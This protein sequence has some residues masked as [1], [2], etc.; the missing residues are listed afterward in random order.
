MNQPTPAALMSSTIACGRA[1]ASRSPSKSA[2]WSES[3]ARS[4]RIADGVPAASNRFHA[5]VK[6]NEGISQIQSRQRTLSK[7]NSLGEPKRIHILRSGQI[8]IAR[9]EHAASDRRIKHE[10]RTEFNQRAVRASRTEDPDVRSTAWTGGDDD[11]G[12]TIEIHVTD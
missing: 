8:R 12:E 4:S 1:S 6:H 10:L 9:D 11:V 2:T 7:F 3:T 5:G